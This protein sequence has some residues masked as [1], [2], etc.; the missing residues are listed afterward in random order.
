M[1][2]SDAGEARVR[3]YLFVLGRALD[4]FLPK[5]TARDALQEIEGHIRE[6]VGEV[7]ADPDERTA[8]ERMLDQLGSPQ[9]VARAYSGEMAIEEAVA[10]GRFAPTARAL[11]HLATTTMLG[12]FAA[13]GLFVGY[14]A[15][16]SFLAVAVAKPIFPNNTGVMIIDGIPRALG[17]FAPVPEG[18][19]VAGGY[20]LIPISLALGLLVLV[21]TQRGTMRF[22]GWWKGRRAADGRT[23]GGLD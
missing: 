3:G 12:F 16:L 6:R 20:W 15:G 11:W 10:T 19:V 9:R 22:L 4:S 2:L 14:I 8:L 7:D 18:A 1:R 17:I 21:A 5:E 23:R 13:L